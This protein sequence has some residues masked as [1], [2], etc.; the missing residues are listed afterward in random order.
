M[1]GYILDAYD[2]VVAALQAEGLT[3]ITD[4][5]NVRPPCV[6]VEPPSI[7][8]NQN[9][10]LAQLDFPITVLAPPPGNKDAL[11]WLLDTADEIVGAVGPTTG[12][13]T[14]YTIGNQDLPAY[15]LT[16]TVQIRRS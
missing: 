6:L 2:W 4:P 11:N 13:P 8:Q 1:A 5:R 16:A 10:T 15:T 9:K 14:V 7:T 3:V 12:S